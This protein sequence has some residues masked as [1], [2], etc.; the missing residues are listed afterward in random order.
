MLLA[1]TLA[2]ARKNIGENGA[3]LRKTF[4]ASDRALGNKRRRLAAAL[5]LATRRRLPALRCA[6]LLTAHTAWRAA[7]ARR[8]AARAANEHASA[9]PLRDLSR[10]RVNSAAVRAPLPSA[11]TACRITTS[12]AALFIWF[13]LWAT[14]HYLSQRTLQNAA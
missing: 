5:A 12:I 10:H 6:R 8:A 3:R 13:L 4:T 1:S 9:A 2:A 7:S 11:K 14:G